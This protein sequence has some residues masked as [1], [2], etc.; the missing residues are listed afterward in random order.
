MIVFWKPVFMEKPTLI[1]AVFQVFRVL[2][3]EPTI[4]KVL[5]NGT[6]GV[7]G[8]LCALM[9]KNSRETAAGRTLTDSKMSWNILP[10]NCMGNYKPFFES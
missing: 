4:T 2:W 8:A 5:M 6:F 10:Q 9:M 3:L 7:A 1:F